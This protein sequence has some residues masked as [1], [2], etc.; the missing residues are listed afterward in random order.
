MTFRA[1]LH[2]HSTCSDGSL[3]PNELVDLAIKKGLQGLS[4]TDH[5]AFDAYPEVLNYATQNGLKMVT[6]VEFSASLNG[7]SVHILGYGFDPQNKELKAFSGR[8]RDRRIARNRELLEKLLKEGI[9]LDENELYASASSRM[10]GR[11]HIALLMVKHGFVK[12]VR[13]A[14]KKYL[15]DGAKCYVPG[16]QFTIEETLDHLRR[17]GGKPVLAHPHLYDGKKFVKKILDK[18]FWGM[19]CNYGS[20]TIPQNAPW[21]SLAAELGL[22]K[23]AGSDYHGPYKTNAELGASFVSEEVFTLLST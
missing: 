1:D 15:G 19:E 20:L 16:P 17:A 11:P 4:I 7:K 2:C 23:T 10:I 12:D 6:G 13:T 9:P 3:T 21:H 8:H 18:G 5:D 22:H 14:F